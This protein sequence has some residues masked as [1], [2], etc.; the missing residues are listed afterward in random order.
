[1][2]DNEQLED[3]AVECSQME[4]VVALDVCEERVC[5][6]FEQQVDYVHLTSLDRPASRRSDGLAAFGVHLCAL[7][8]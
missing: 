5:A 8:D 7:L 4:E 2:K 1:M 6:I 3:I